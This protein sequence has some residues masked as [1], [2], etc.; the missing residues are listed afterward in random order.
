MRYDEFEIERDMG[1]IVLEKPL[2]CGRCLKPMEVIGP[3]FYAC[4]EC[5][6]RY[7]TLTED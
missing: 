5:G 3:G 2:R 1:G 7:D 6:E 4:P